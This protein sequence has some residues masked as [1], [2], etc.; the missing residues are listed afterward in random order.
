MNEYGS[1]LFGYCHCPKQT[2]AKKCLSSG[3]KSDGRDNNRT[4]APSA[5]PPCRQIA[6]QKA[7]TAIVA[8]FAVW[9]KMP[10][11]S[12]A[13]KYSS[14]V[15]VLSFSAAWLIAYTQ[16]C[17]SAGLKDYKALILLN[18]CRENLP[19]FC[20]SGGKNFSSAFCTHPCTESMNLRMRSLFGLECHFH[21]SFLLFSSDS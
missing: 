3:G 11:L 19:A 20:P 17:M 18:L 16:H 1:Y 6:A 5:V 9:Q 14:P 7:C 15:A 21:I 2:A 8:A 10:S 4:S 12:R 13:I